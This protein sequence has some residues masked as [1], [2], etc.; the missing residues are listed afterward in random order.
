MSGYTTRQRALIA[1]NIAICVACAVAIIVG[2]AVHSGNQPT[3]PAPSPATAEPATQPPPSPVAPSA[4]PPPTALEF[5]ETDRWTFDGTDVTLTVLDFDPDRPSVGAQPG[6]RYA[7]ADVKQCGGVPDYSSWSVADTDSGVYE[8]TSTTYQD[9]PKPEFPFA[10]DHLLSPGQCVHGW[11]MFP[12]AEDARIAAV[13][14]SG[15]G[16]QS[17]W[18]VQ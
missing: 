7:A 15:G 1:T 18:K 12:V 2:I 13:T 17:T 10:A 3:P 16:E 5:G 8:A 11:V 4:A 9:F 6:E 14:F